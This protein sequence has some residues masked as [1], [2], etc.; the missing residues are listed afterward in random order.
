MILKRNCQIWNKLGTINSG[1][2][3]T[4]VTRFDW[5]VPKEMSLSRMVTKPSW[6]MV[7]VPSWST[8]SPSKVKT[9]FSSVTPWNSWP[10]ALDK[11]ETSAPLMA[12]PLTKFFTW[13][14]KVTGKDWKKRNSNKSKTMIFWSWFKWTASNVWL[15]R[16]RFYVVKQKLETFQDIGSANAHSSQPSA[17]PR[18]WNCREKISFRALWIRY[19]RSSASPGPPFLALY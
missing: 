2:I 3:W 19:W 12:S 15:I 17:N 7:T 11:N 8:D 16:K 10:V 4:T 1:F 9:P 13:R 6:T 14:L 5:L 18:S